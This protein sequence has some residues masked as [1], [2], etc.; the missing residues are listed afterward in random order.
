[1]KLPQMGKTIRTFIAF[2]MPATFL[3]LAEGLQDRLRNRGVRLRWVRPQNIHLTLKFL[4]DILP[5]Q[6]DDVVSAMNRASGTESSIALTAQGMGVFP[7][8]KKPRVLWI[9]MGGQT[10][11]LAQTVAT[12]ENC[13]EGAGFPPERRPFRA[14]LTLGRMKHAL[15]S[16]QLLQAIEHEGCFEPEPFQ[17]TEMVL[18][19][20]DLRPQGAIYTPLARVPLGQ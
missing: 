2:E 19:K 5:E 9:G 17:A 16:R 8:I 11:R 12:L 6:M 7:G 10:D 4:G 1:M 3:R 13:L 18:F 14:H 15:D 20:S